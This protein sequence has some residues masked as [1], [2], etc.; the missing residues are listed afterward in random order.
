MG[1]ASCLKPS[2]ARKNSKQNPLNPAHHDCHGVG[3]VLEAL[4]ELDELLVHQGVGLQLNL[5]L[6]LLDLG[7]GGS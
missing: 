5:E 1:W 4:V 3:V 6:A 7:G 2:P